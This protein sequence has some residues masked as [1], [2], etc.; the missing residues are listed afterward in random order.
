MVP[1]AQYYSK[2]TL[3][4]KPVGDGAKMWGVAL[5]TRC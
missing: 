1:K 5:K 2:D 4:L 3:D